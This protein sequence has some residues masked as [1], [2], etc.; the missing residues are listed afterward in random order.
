MANTAGLAFQIL[1]MAGAFSL[2]A[3]IGLLGL[4]VSRKTLYSPLPPPLPMYLEHADAGGVTFW[5]VRS[6]WVAPV[7]I[8]GFLGMCTLFAFL[9]FGNIASTGAAEP[10]SGNVFNGIAANIIMFLFLLLI[11][12]ALVYRRIKPVA[13][14][15]LR[16]SRWYMVCFSPLVVFAI[17]ILM[18]WLMSVGYFEWM[19]R[20]S[21]APSTQ[22]AVKILRDSQDGRVLGLMAF[23]A[24]IVAP[25]VEETIFRG[26]LYPA[27]KRWIG[28]LPALLITSLVF[29][30][31]HGSAPLVLPL[32]ALGV[33]LVLAYESTGSIWM[34]I[35]IHACFNGATVMMQMA[36]RFGWIPDVANAAP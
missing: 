31:G 15:G 34:P 33:L 20:M 8:A 9:C 14:L 30:A 36:V 22:E 2:A 29:A 4:L 35:A 17:W 11:T 3:L 1:V 28:V 19:E 10:T 26:Y 24:V 32:L 12:V 23:T 16:W 27:V 13:W 21:G 18:G 7:D 6:D 25:V 5:R